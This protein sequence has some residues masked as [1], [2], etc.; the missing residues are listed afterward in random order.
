VDHRSSRVP[1][2]VPCPSLGPAQTPVVQSAEEEAGGGHG[3]LRGNYMQTSRPC[4]IGPVSDRERR[5]V[6]HMPIRAWVRNG[7]TYRRTRGPWYV[8]ECVSIALEKH[9]SPRNSV[10]LRRGC[11]LRPEARRRLSREPERRRAVERSLPKWADPADLLAG[12]A[13]GPLIDAKARGQGKRPGSGVW[14]SSG[15]SVTSLRAVAE[16]LIR[17]GY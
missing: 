14:G 1:A 13:P 8:H 9:Q 4:I 3:E 6:P 17:G 5:A 7:S 10:M 2:F 15:A 11:L 12:V 16:A